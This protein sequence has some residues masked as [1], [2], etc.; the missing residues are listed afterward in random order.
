MFFDGRRRPSTTTIGSGTPATFPTSP[1]EEPT[2]IF[3]G[4]GCRPI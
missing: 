3:R 1:G 4:E 2:L